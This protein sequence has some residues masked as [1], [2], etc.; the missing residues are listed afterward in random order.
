M[1]ELDAALVG[2]D[3]LFFDGPGDQPVLPVAEASYGLSLR[4]I[5]LASFR[6]IDAARVE[7]VADTVEAGFA[8]DMEPIVGAR[9][10]GPKGLARSRAALLEIFVEHLLPASG[11]DTRRVRYHTVQVEQD[12]VVAVA[13]DWTSVAGFLHRSLPR[14]KAI[15]STKRPFSDLNG[16]D[17]AVA[18]WNASIPPSSRKCWPEWAENLIQHFVARAA[19]A[20]DRLAWLGDHLLA[21][22][23]ELRGQNS[24]HQAAA[25]SP[26]AFSSDLGRVSQS[27][28]VAS[29]RR[30]T[31]LSASR[32]AAAGIYIDGIVVA[33]TRPSATCV[34]HY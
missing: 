8:V 31:I 23:Y 9:I 24:L 2:V 7:E 17:L 26:N 10:E 22:L 6:Q 13:C 34:P 27:T 33:R 3:T 29:R 19:V 20:E 5:V 16:R 28:A 30:T 12:G 4:R 18:A 15:Q 11:V 14:T 25:T 1:D 32:K 21:K